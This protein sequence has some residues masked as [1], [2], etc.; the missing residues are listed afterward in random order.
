MAAELNVFNNI[1]DRVIEL[2]PETKE[3]P[4]SILNIGKAAHILE[5]NEIR[6]I[7]HLFIVL[8]QG[9]PNFYGFGKLK[10]QQLFE[11]VRSFLTLLDD[12]GK[13][14]SGTL[15]SKLNLAIGPAS[16]A[17]LSFSIKTKNLI[18]IFLFIMIVNICN[19]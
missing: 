12:S 3:L 17:T 6:N 10:Q 18:F 8:T 14:A 2:H 9:F 4:L 7:G 1:V 5:Q 13:I 16:G 15:F 11:G 19:L